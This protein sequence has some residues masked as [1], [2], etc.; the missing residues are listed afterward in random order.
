MFRKVLIANRGEIAVRVLRTLREMGVSSVAVFSEADRTALHVRY[1]DEA[2]CLGP[3]PSR[4]S[5]LDVGKVI[6]A[7]RQT[8]AEAIH[9]GYGFLSERAHFARACAEAGIVFIGPSPDAIEAMGEKTGARARMRAA[10]VPV[11]PGSDGPIQDDQALAIASHI[12]YPILVKA[13][14]GGGGKGMRV[15]DRPEDLLAAVAGARREAAAAFG[16][17]SVYLEK[18]LLGPRHV[19]IQVFGD[20]HGNV[21]HLFERECSVQRRH[22]KVIE[23]SP[24]CALTPEL[25]AAMCAVAVRA[26][27]A[28]R[29]VGA[30]T[31]ELLVDAH[32]H[33]Y[34]LEM[35]TRLQVEHPVT[36]MI[37]GRD[38]VRLQLEVAA[39]EPLPF[40]Q[41]DLTRRGH[42]IECRI[43][44]ED[45]DRDFL[46]APGHI[47]DLRLPGGVGVR[48]D[49]GVYPG[50]DVPMHY[51]P[52]LGKLITWAET[53]EMAI[54]R[55][56]RAL[57]ELTIKGIATNTRYLAQILEHPRFRS[58]DY[59]THLLQEIAPAH[60]GTSDEEDLALAVAAIYASRPLA[61][62]GNGAA[63]KA[64]SSE[65]KPRVPGGATPWRLVS[66]MRTLSRG[67]HL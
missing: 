29:Y 67:G 34:F 40:R 35:N 8:G 66:R 5:Y 30:G 7:A 6:A 48:I 53:R 22:Q 55:M 16:D 36:E 28:V 24:S 39:G 10:N 43:Y 2:V 20:T 65:R 19:E 57:Q 56:R 1:A 59:D 54:A 46:P 23:E 27:Q 38:L 32:R 42:A 21:V 52:M 15:V 51:D 9:P 4:E 13:A 62:N 41:E 17:D 14:A 49:L 60:R 44:A 58:G 47:E 12:G 26:A 37:T 25:R 45:P 31:V 61:T 18:Y 63:P 3:A 50:F 11:V 33:F 64:P